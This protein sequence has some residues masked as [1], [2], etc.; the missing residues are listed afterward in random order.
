MRTLSYASK[1]FDSQLAEF[2]RGS[3]VPKA[4]ARSVASILAGVRERGDAAVAAYALKF[5]GARLAPRRFRV[6]GAEIAAAA[7]GLSPASRRALEGK[8]T[9]RCG[10][11]T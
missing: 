6:G 10:S 2:T 1:Q 7:R 5:D 3:A 8:S 11:S 9:V 4:I